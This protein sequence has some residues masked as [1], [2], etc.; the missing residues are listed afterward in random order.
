VQE[1]QRQVIGLT[2]KMSSIERNQ[3]EL[4]EERNNQIETARRSIEDLENRLAESD[5]RVQQVRLNDHLTY[6]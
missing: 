3:V 5:A 4:L 6:F 1:H 2:D